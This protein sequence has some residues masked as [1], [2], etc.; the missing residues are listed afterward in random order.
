MRIPNTVSV[1][2]LSDVR[3]LTEDNFS[4][5]FAPQLISQPNLIELSLKQL[6]L[7]LNKGPVHDAFIEIL[8]ANHKTL[9]VLDLSGNSIFDE[10]LV[11]ISNLAGIE[12]TETGYS[13]L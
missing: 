12:V 7:D 5:V 10:C 9:K 11:A 8:R 6:R 1:L 2:E 4:L 3:C 13:A